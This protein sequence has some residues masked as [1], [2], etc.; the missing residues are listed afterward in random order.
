MLDALQ[1]E[2]DRIADDAGARVVI[3]APPARRSRP[4]TT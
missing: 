3:L 4:A 2:L 1:A